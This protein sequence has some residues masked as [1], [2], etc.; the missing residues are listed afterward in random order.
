MVQQ[1]VVLAQSLGIPGPELADGLVQECTALGGAG[2]DEG[3]ILRAEENG[4]D[5][6]G[7]FSGGLAFDMIDGE[8]SPGA[9]EKLGFDEKFPPP[10]LHL[11]GD[12]SP[13]PVEG[14]ELLV[15]PGS[16]GLG[17]RGDWRMPSDAVPLDM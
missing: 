5:D 6:A 3:Q 14:D 12:G 15:P 16:V 17:P 2:L 10:A 9:P 13:V 4:L 1:F 7:E 8:L 11:G